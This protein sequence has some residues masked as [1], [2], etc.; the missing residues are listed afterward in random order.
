[1]CVGLGG[2]I[3]V[4]ER[5]DKI[6]GCVHD[7]ADETG[8]KP[9]AGYVETELYEASGPGKN[10]V[11]RVEFNR[12]DKE[13]WSMDGHL[14]SK[15][16]VRHCLRH[17]QRSTARDMLKTQLRLIPTLKPGVARIAE[18][19]STAPLG[20]RL[21]TRAEAAAFPCGGSI[22]ERKRV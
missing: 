7:N 4:T 8:Q 13:I 22:S 10:L 5:G 16:K 19:P 6:S 2:P 3:K 9:E 11:V 17:A 12:Q 1:M 20:P 18:Q 21:R 14:T 15:K